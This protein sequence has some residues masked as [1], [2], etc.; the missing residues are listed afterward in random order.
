MQCLPRMSSNYSYSVVKLLWPFMAFDSRVHV[1]TIPK[2]PLLP[3][4]ALPPGGWAIECRE[5]LL[6]FVTFHSVAPTL[7]R[8]HLFSAWHLSFAVSQ[9]PSGFP[10]IRG[11]CNL[12]VPTRD[13]EGGQMREPQT[14]PI[15]DHGVPV[16][17]VL[18]GIP[19]IAK[20]DDG[21]T[22]VAGLRTYH[23]K[24]EGHIFFVRESDLE[25]PKMGQSETLIV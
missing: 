19:V 16:E 3:R 8:K 13:K 6:I 24:T 15:C 25:K 21:R 17:R 12:V 14:C 9:H 7:R 2:G 23:C 22:E 4:L 20:V 10:S 18:P 1:C 11:C 5:G